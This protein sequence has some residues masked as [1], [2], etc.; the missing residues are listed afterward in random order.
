ML[1]WVPVAGSKSKW[2]TSF[3]A[4]PACFSVASEG[5]DLRL[6]GRHLCFGVVVAQAVAQRTGKGVGIDVA[7]HGNDHA[8]RAF[9]GQQRGGIG[10][11][12]RPVQRGHVHLEK[13]PGAQ[14]R[15]VEHQRG[16]GHLHRGRE[17]HPLQLGGLGVQRG[18]RQGPQRQR[19][20]GRGQRFQNSGHGR[21]TFQIIN[22]KLFIPNKRWVPIWLKV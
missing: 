2:M 3:L 22:S 8:A 14:A 17:F 5:V 12:L 1:T 18:G 15:P 21:Q 7:Q 19:R 6:Q 4:S 9:L 16:A 10:G 11:F 20:G 13:R